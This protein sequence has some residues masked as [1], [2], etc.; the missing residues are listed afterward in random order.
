MKVDDTWYAYLAD[1]GA[2][3]GLFALMTGISEEFYCAG[4]MMGL[5]HSLWGMVE[6]GPRGY[7][8]GTVSERHVELLRLLAEESDG[9]WT[10]ANDEPLFIALNVWKARVA[11]QR[12]PAETPIDG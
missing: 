7:G 10:W 3:I 12:R 8:M 5:E 9:W 4:W 11:D 2:R 6:G 1:E